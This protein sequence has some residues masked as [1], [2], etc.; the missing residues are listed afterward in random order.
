MKKQRIRI[1]A[2]ILTLAITFIAHPFIVVKAVTNPSGILTTTLR[3][4]D[5]DDTS[6]TSYPISRIITLNFST[7]Q[8]GYAEFSLD[9]AITPDQVNIYGATYSAGS[10]TFNIHFDNTKFI[11]IEIYFRPNMAV[12]DI[13]SWDLYSV[14]SENHIINIENSTEIIVTTLDEINKQINAHLG[15]IFIQ[16]NRGLT[17]N[18]S[19]SFT[20]F[21]ANGVYMNLSNVS[22]QRIDL[23]F[24]Y[25]IANGNYLAFT[26]YLHTSTNVT[27]Q[28]LKSIRIRMRD[29]KGYI[30][31][32][33][34]RYVYYQSVLNSDDNK[35]DV[36]ITMYI[37]SYLIIEDNNTDYMFW[38]IIDQITIP[39]CDIFGFIMRGMVEQLPEESYLN[40]TPAEASDLTDTT[41]NLNT[42]EETIQGFESLVDEQLTDFNE[43][44]NLNDY[45]FPLHFNS[46]TFQFMK[47]TL[48]NFYNLA[49]LRPFYVIPIILFIFVKILG[50]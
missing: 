9:H 36:S 13:L 26:L 45:K 50:G 12:V 23:R 33:N 49:D 10:T 22:S 1:A 8:T 35:Y 28:T 6:T 24:D 48:G 25:N 2:L 31:N 27:D 18:T 47:Q 11:Y 30:T 16:V 19:A 32:I 43:N 44:V 39:G 3:Y 38:F 29:M 17:G 15:N 34:T 42:L 7:E 46:Q 41:D 14:D 20:D 21:N 4:N 37:P 5:P 40:S